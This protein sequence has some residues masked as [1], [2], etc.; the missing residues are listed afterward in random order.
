MCTK[1]SIQPWRITMATL[2][3]FVNW[4]CHWQSDQWLTFGNT[5]KQFDFLVDISQE[6]FTGTID[7]FRQCYNMEHSMP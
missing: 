2:D 4:K 7:L 6:Q 1:K 3:I 5:N